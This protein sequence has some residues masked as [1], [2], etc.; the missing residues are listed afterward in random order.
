V[1]PLDVLAVDAVRA[2]S[3][4]RCYHCKRAIFTRLT[5]EA[6][7]AGFPLV[8]EGSNTDDLADY[9]PGRRAL[10]EMGIHSP[11][12]RAGLSKAEIRTL[13][14]RLGLPTASKPSAACLA[15]RFAYGE[16]I[17]REGLA[18][19]D[20]AERFLRARGFSQARVRV[21]GNLARIEVQPALVPDIVSEP[22]RTELLSHMR[23]LGFAYATVDLAGYRTGS[24]NEVL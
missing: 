8:V 5:E 18:R 12:L 14:E 10:E 13:S 6:Q 2:N 19:V 7:A 20:A 11:L 16:Q 9:R 15:S 24:M 1:V 23:D 21:H 17:T 4:N 22:L 3:A